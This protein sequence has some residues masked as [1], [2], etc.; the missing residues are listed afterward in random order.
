L[1][2]RSWSWAV[3]GVR[4]DNSGCGGDVTND[5][6][7]WDDDARRTSWRGGDWLGESA[8]AVGDGQ[9]LALGCGV[10][11]SIAGNDGGSLRAESGDGS[12]NLGGNS[13]VVTS[14]TGEVD[15]LGGGSKAK[16]GEDLNRLHYEDWT[17]LLMSKN[18]CC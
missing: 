1:D 5:D 13:R 16:D 17:G 14:A 6:R 10:G 3:S 4:S 15:G 11:L 12:D 9:G 2:N 8:R 7:G 18:D